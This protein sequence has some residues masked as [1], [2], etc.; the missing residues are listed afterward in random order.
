MLRL[1]KYILI[2]SSC[3]LLASVL[4]A[5]ENADLKKA[6]ENRA[7]L[8]EIEERLDTVEK[9]TLVDRLDL[10]MD[11]RMTLNNY[12]YRDKSGEATKALGLLNSDGET[13][14]LW[15]MR[16]RLKMKA[17]L[18]ESFK[19]TAWLSMYKQFIESAPGRYENQLVV[20]TYDLSKGYY[21][22][23]SSVYMERMYV[24]WFV[25][26]WLAIS[27]GRISTVDGT[28]SDTRYGTVPLGTFPESIL[29]TPFDGIYATFSLKRAGLDNSFIRFWYS[30][31]APVDSSISNNLFILS[32]DSTMNCGGI[33]ADFDIPKTNGWR[34]YASIALLPQLKLWN[35]YRD[36]NSDGIDEKL[37]ISNNLGGLYDFYLGL[38]MP[39]PFDLPFDFFMSGHFEINTTPG[40]EGSDPNTGFIGLPVDDSNPVSTPLST[41]LGN[42]LNGKNSYGWHL[43]ASLAW[44][45]P[46]KMYES[47]L[48]VGANFV[49]GSKYFWLYFAPD[50]TGL[51]MF[52]IRGK[53]VEAYVLIPI[54]RKANLRL[55]YI[56]QHHDH[57]WGQFFAPGQ[58]VP[59]ISEE[60]H[61]FNVMLNVY[62]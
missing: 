53:N 20:P 54:N 39:K 6:I 44:E 1:C 22:G 24:D 47:Y 34:V 18:S 7:R 17:A 52:G 21:P 32:T 59:G 30:P 14:G 29:N 37:Y 26:D 28:P 38:R 42:S 4:F 12:I 15:N 60:I 57:P 48:T 56:F 36:V 8:D 5:Q 23:N 58:G 41:Y 46:I 61:N 13:F 25:T 40:R 55:G 9:K 33:V 16:G 19:L 62:F 31:L 11:V 3:F 50:T 45:T 35:L 51:N 49:Y 43:Y 2:L 10:S 27:A